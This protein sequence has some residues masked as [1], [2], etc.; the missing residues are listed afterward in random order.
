MGSGLPAGIPDRRL[1][2]A[3]AGDNRRRDRGQDPQ[4]G[5]GVDQRLKVSYFTIE[6]EKE[7]KDLT[8]FRF[9]DRLYDV[10]VDAARRQNMVVLPDRRLLLVED[11]V[12]VE[13][14]FFKPSNMIDTGKTIEQFVV[15]KDQEFADAIPVADTIS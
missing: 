4:E 11:W 8:I 1:C 13:E 7:R 12:E 5:S 10:D 6:K 15:E 14:D 2:R 3:A 9:E